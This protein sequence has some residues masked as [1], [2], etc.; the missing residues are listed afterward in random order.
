M[1]PAGR[2]ENYS[3]R[4]PSVVIQNTNR[5][6]RVLEVTKTVEDARDRATA[7]E[8]DF[9]TLNTAQWCERYDGPPSFVSG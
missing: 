4:E 7:N 1:T 2:W 5:E 8:Q 3:G 9:K 6:K